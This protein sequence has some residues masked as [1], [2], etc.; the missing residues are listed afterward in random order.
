MSRHY[1]Y[2]GTPGTC[3]WCGRKFREIPARVFYPTMMGV[4]S[5]K[6]GDDIGEY[7]VVR[8]VVELTGTGRRARPPCQGD[9]VDTVKVYTDRRYYDALW[10]DNPM[11]DT[12]GCAVMF[13]LALARRGVRVGP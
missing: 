5:P 2:V 1:G 3:L 8:R 4:V 6:V 7:G 11:F 12:N 9:P 13:G 10:S